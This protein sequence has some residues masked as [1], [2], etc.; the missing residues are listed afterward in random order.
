MSA[1]AKKL[2]LLELANSGADRPKQKSELGW[3]LAHYV[4][5][6]Q[7]CYDEQFD[8]EIRKLRPDWFKS[9]AYELKKIKDRMPRCL[10]FVPGQDWNG[11]KRR[12]LFKCEYGGIF[13]MRLG[14]IVYTKW[15]KG[16]CGC[17]NHK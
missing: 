14:S 7:S 4:N 17:P 9:P 10:S 8:T 15:P 3:T 11:H 13:Y 2:Q 16:V 5:R 1:Y 12:Y 6:S